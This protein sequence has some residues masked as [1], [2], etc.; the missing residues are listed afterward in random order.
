MNLAPV[1]ALWETKVTE[2]FDNIGKTGTVH[3]APTPSDCPNCIYDSVRKRSKNIYDSSN[4]NPAG[5]LNKSFASGQI[6]PVCNG[7]G[8]LQT[9]NS[10]SQRFLVGRPTSN[11]ALSE[12]EMLRIGV[13][14]EDKLFTTS[15]IS[16]YNALLNAQM[17]TINGR[18]YVPIAKPQKTGM[19]D[20][21]L[22]RMLWRL[23]SQ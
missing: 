16:A 23:E 15:P 9:P 11:S 1:I 2:M 17:L 5:A 22:V 4:P 14:T 21:F 19:G 18:N 10:S 6:C 12:Q 3:E 13:H 20:P 8:I 7:A